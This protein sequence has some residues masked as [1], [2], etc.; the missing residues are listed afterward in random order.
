M[1]QIKAVID[2]GTNSIKFCVAEGTADGYKVLFDTNNIARLGEGMKDT[3]SIA[4]EAL[5][6]NAQAVA[7]FVEEA[8]KRGADEIR[9]VGTMAL[10]VAK[11]AAY[12]V[13]RVR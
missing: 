10:R 1:A 13:A 2:V 9:V 7:E 11:N 6:R 3:G 4:S 8:K 12:F 5:E